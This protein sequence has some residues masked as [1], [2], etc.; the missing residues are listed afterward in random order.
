MYPHPSHFDQSSVPPFYR[1]HKIEMCLAL[2]PSGTNT[3]S[4]VHALA[5]G[6]TA[7]LL[8]PLLAW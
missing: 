7:D 4:S 3:P 8:C 1:M 2:D 5:A 6:V